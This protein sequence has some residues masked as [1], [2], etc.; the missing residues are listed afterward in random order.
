VIVKRALKNIVSNVDETIQ[1]YTTKLEGLKEEFQL[2][3][4]LHTGTAVERVE[5]TV[6]RVLAEIKQLCE[7]ILPLFCI[8]TKYCIQLNPSI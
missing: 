2:R 5:V 4:A 1:E 6:I 7:Y 3:L 8:R